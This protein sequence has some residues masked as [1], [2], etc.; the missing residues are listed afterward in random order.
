MPLTLVL[1]PANSA[2]AGE[3][4]SAFAAAASRDALLVV[5]TSLDAEHYTRELAE[6]G[7]LVGTVV[8]FAGLAREIAR[9]A[10]YHGHVITPL[11]RRRLL[12]RLLAGLRLPLLGRSA[13]SRGFPAAAA[14]LIAE[15][16]RSLVSP[17]RLAQALGA[18]SQQDPRRAGYAREVGQLYMAYTRELERLDRV[19]GELLAWRGLDALRA[20]P[21]RW[22]D[23]PV[24]LYGFDDLLAVEQDAVETLARVAGAQVTVSLTY[25]PRRAAFDARAGV[26]Q[27]LRAW[28]SEVRELP[29]LDEF[30]APHARRV[31]HHLERWLFE[32]AGERL[33]PGPAVRLL[34]A[35]GELAQ[36]ELIAAE[37]LSLREHGF[38]PQE[39]VVVCRSL[40][41]AGPLLTGVLQGY[42]IP[43]AGDRRIRFSQT[44][45]GRA[46]QA[47]ARCAGVEDREASAED[48]L[49]LLRAPGIVEPEPVDALEA[50]IR[51]HGVRSL[52]E[53]RRRWHP[54]SEGIEAI[55]ALRG[56]ED[57]AAELAWQA[58][59]LFAAP[60]RRRAPVLG[61]GEELDAR[62]LAVLASALQEAAELGEAP[63]RDE[64]PALLDEL[65]V[66]AGEPPRN[67][68]VLLA[69][70]LSIRAR[71]FRAVIVCGLNEGEFPAPAAEE[72]FLS[73]QH[74]RELAIASG[75]RL[76]PREDALA[77]ERYLLYA[78][79]S[80][81]T[82]RVVL[83]YRSSDEEG[84]LALP[85]PFIGDVAELLDEEWRARRAQRLLADVVWDAQ[86][87]PTECERA[88]ALAAAA[89]GGNG[90]AIA[91]APRQLGQAAL[92]HVRHTEVVS[93]GALEKYAECP[94]KWL[95]ESQLDPE[96]F[97]TEPEPMA[98]GTFMHETLERVFRRLGEPLTPAT[99]PEALVITSEEVRSSGADVA[100]AR[101]PAVR[102]ALL[103]GYEADLG[104][105]LAAEAADGCGWRPGE[106]EV[107]FGFDDKDRPSLPAVELGEGEERIRLRGAIDRV[108][109]DP[110]DGARAIVRDYKSGVARPEQAAARWGGESR[111]QVALYMVAVRALLGLDPVAGFYQP[112]RG[113]DLRPRGVFLSGQPVGTRAVGTDARER[114][115]LDALLAEAEGSAVALAGEIRRGLLTPRPQ[116]CSREGCRYPGI[117]R[118][119]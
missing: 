59:R 60:H 50:A 107:R 49:A 65:E 91:E 8:T 103:Q 23:T 17:Q 74:R 101:S 67:D 96:R 73:D 88:R 35:G 86:D 113:A 83:S 58:R 25:E 66:P 106:L 97:E 53:A 46:V 93:A 16:E 68:A 20:Q 71:R 32:P 48:L 105:Y 80:R 102:A 27:E 31:L 9:R 3:V 75:L 30:Y 87:A 43:V 69:E 41:A 36:A 42:G 18:W 62:A 4:L 37:V 26:V 38:A 76:P 84:N 24:F 57:P 63:G 72:P 47:L 77:R 21:G 99:L 82:E 119:S 117:C 92:A 64:L 29:A 109:V 44:S 2:K 28:A 56:A 78:C 116:S 39:I 94:V 45:L 10:G 111:L 98:R 12:R 11:A 52:A 79:L 90:G 40:A 19:D 1:G 6:Q 54:R 118:S 108:D 7:G 89:A 34:E 13:S 104:R 112:L 22:G 61:A 110:D 70:P 81:A 115:Q 114:D 55:D 100:P 5:P 15:L 95:V 85:S 51:R 14:A 33:H